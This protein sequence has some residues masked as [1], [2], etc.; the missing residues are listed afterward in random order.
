MGFEFGRPFARLWA[1]DV[2]EVDMLRSGLVGIVGF[3]AW[4]SLAAGLNLRVGEEVGLW[5]QK[6]GT[7]FKIRDLRDDGL[8]QVTGPSDSLVVSQDQ[9]IHLQG[10]YKTFRVGVA[11]LHLVKRN[12]Q[13]EFRARSYSVE[14]DGLAGEKVVIAGLRQV[15]AGQTFLVVKDASGSWRELEEDFV[16]QALPKN[17]L[18][19]TFYLN[20]TD[21]KSSSLDLGI[22]EFEVVGSIP[23]NEAVVLQL[24]KEPSVQPKVDR[25][26]LHYWLFKRDRNSL[27]P[28]TMESGNQL[29]STFFLSVEAERGVESQFMMF[30]DPEP[31]AVAAR[32]GW[33][34]TLKGVALSGR[35]YLQSVIGQVDYP[36]YRHEDLGQLHGSAEG[37]SYGERV[38]LVK[39]SKVQE[40]YVVAIYKNQAV[41]S[42]EK[43]DSTAKMLPV[44]IGAQ[45]N[46]YQIF[47]PN[48]RPR[49]AQFYLDRVYPR[50]VISETQEGWMVTRNSAREPE[51]WH[52]SNQVGTSGMAK[53]LTVGEKF[54]LRSGEDDVFRAQLV[55][56][57]SLRGLHGEMIKIPLVR[58]L[59]GPQSG[60]ILAGL[61]KDQIVVS[62]GTLKGFYVSQSLLFLGPDDLL[63]RVTVV[64]FSGT[65]L[66]LKNHLGE[67][68]LRAEI[69]CERIL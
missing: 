60:R 35:L 18:P 16:V 39:G 31:D 17:L 66:V 59:D 54:L 37:V 10:S 21:A 46:G 61:E 28:R 19:K 55:G 38:F 13:S 57:K 1:L 69:P 8:V 45:A 64:G 53:G 68:F 49:T 26:L 44:V 15:S 22:S 6:A 23:R 65:D 2:N 34:V 56:I 58:M 51:L 27:L 3:L 43:P 36:N 11:V 52:I 33:R 29:G 4:G 30:K 63:S 7:V 12:F 14:R 62:F 47:K 48:D 42:P 9:L 20:N 50:E 67:L 5:N 24:T 32:M 40:V 25:N 41:F